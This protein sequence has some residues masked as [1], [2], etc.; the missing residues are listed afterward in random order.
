MADEETRHVNSVC[1]GA[2]QEKKENI[3][4]ERELERK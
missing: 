1:A 2:E 4:R 3:K